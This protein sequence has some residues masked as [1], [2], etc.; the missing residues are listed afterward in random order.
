MRSD[1]R[2][3]L[4]LGAGTEKEALELLAGAKAR[5]GFDRSTLLQAKVLAESRKDTDRV[6]MLA[7]A[8]SANKE[9][10]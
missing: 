6:K 7:A 2:L 3:V 5:G 4:A 10:R 9:T 8:L 1:A